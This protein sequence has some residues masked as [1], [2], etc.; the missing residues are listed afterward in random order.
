MAG[1]TLFG[2]QRPNL[3]SKVDARF[4]RHHSSGGQQNAPGKDH[5]GDQRNTNSPNT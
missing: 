5:P 4:L 1:K 2:Q 3:T